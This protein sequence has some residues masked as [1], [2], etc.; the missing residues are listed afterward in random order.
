MAQHP[1]EPLGADEFTRT[2][3]ILRREGHFTD[4]FRFASIELLEPAKQEV[5]AWRA[6][7]AVPRH[8][9]AV[10]WNRSDNKTY[11][12]TVD[13]TGDAVLSIKHVPDVTPN[14]T[15]DEFHEVDEALR[16]HP[17]VIAKLRERGIS[18]MSRVIVDVWTYGKAVMPEKYRDRRLGWCDLWVRETPDGNPYAHPVSGLKLD[19]GHEHPGAPRDRGPLRRR[20]AGGRR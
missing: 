16:K 20:N 4:T 19:R 13:L 10:M 5:L 17:D 12:A 2:T 6:G 9:F 15:V 11:E 1:L 8:S 7:D 14:F 18:D 3:E